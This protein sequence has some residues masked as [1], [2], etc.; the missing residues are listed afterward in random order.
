MY[1]LLL[2]LVSYWQLLSHDRA[3]KDF[4]NGMAGKFCELSNI[5]LIT[6]ALTFSFCC[7]LRSFWFFTRTCV[8]CFKI[9][10]LCGKDIQEWCSLVPN[11]AFSFYK[12]CLSPLSC[13]QSANGLR[14][15]IHDII[16]QERGW[17]R[18]KSGF[19]QGAKCNTI[20]TTATATYPV[21]SLIPQVESEG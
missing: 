7:I 1:V 12:I 17:K 5:L 6:V 18:L 16:E 13:F 21:T 19:K 2:L 20:T 10:C 3:L 11:F 14:I 9:F 15:A 4:L 8:L